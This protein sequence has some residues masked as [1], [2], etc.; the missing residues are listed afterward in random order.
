MKK[1]F[2]FIAL[3]A[4]LAMVLSLAA[5][6]LKGNLKLESF[7]VDRSSVKTDY[8]IGEEIDFSGIQA[9]A[10]Y[11]DE[12]LNK[13]Y[14]FN[15][16]TI[17]YAEDIT[18][19][20]GEKEV[21]VSFMDP[22]LNVK[23]E[24]VVVIKVSSETIPEVPE[25][26]IAVQF[27]KPDSL[28]SFDSANN[29]NTELKYGDSG[30]AG[31]F[32]VGNKTYTVGNENAFRFIPKLAVLNDDDTIAAVENFFAVVEMSVLTDDGY[33]ALTAT[34]GEGNLVSYYNG[35]TLIATVDTYKGLYNFTEDAEGLT[36]KI[37]V[38]PSEEHYIFE[39]FNPVVLEVEIVK[40][41]NVY[42]AWELAVI[43]ND[44][45]DGR[46][47]DWDAHA[48]DAFKNEKGIANVTAS[49]IVLHADLT[50]TVEDVPAVF[51]MTTEKD[52]VYKN[53]L[54]PEETITIPAGTK[55]LKDWS[56]IYRRLMVADETFVVEGNFFSINVS[57]FPLIA[58]PAVFGEEGVLD[59]YGSD[60]S[61]A[62]LFQFLNDNDTAV[63]HYPTVN[64][65]NLSIIGNAARN[66]TVDADGNLV[67]AGGLI[68][69]K[70]TYQVT[71]NFDNMLGNSFFITYFADQ[72]S[73][74]NVS[75]VK[76]YDSYQNAIYMWSNATATFVDSYFNGAGGPMAIAA[77][78][79][80]DNVY[81][82]PTFVA[83]NTV[84]ETHV[85]GEEV[86]FSAVNG[87]SIVTAIQ[88]LSQGMKQATLGSLFNDDGKMNIQGLLMPEGSDATAVI[89][90]TDSQGS[91]FI[92]GVGMDRN[93]TAENAQ[94][95]IIKQISDYALATGG[96]AMLPPFLT[97]YDAQGNAYTIY[98]NG[99]TFVDLAGNELN[100]YA[101]ANHLAIFAAFQA[102]DSIVLTQGGLSVVLEFYH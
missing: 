58:S 80:I 59:D 6:V 19:T 70:S 83:T 97:A 12:S 41:Y 40:A 21:K 92:D 87:T 79:K 18:D 76:C 33:V 65:Q 78:P 24:T 26:S 11:S 94:W 54:K 3:V 55:Y 72:D 90:G 75:N 16:L 82:R 81:Q 100:P 67:S 43:D 68:F 48:W 64:M 89:A 39:A 71:A 101:D 37:S 91:L 95:A 15:E 1:T 98:Y 13:V 96:P 66:N 61:N 99:T 23:Q 88:A 14:T 57:Q 34:A 30:F 29:V 22:N 28:V 62:T 53:A 4:A 50:L 46:E 56:M 32:A 27:E 69:L 17:T 45:T 85:S 44:N 102:A 77:S 7:T 42:E 20:V 8:L 9:T 47:E 52:V 73:V 36:V 2:K 86:W 5:C 25:L 31:E 10:K 63:D 93:Q 74:M 51:F 60:F 38:L 84:F 49:G 35:E